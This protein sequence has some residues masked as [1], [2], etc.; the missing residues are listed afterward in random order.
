MEARIQYLFM[1]IGSN[2]CEKNTLAGTDNFI[3]SQTFICRLAP[4]VKENY[5]RNCESMKQRNREAVVI[6]ASN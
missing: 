2:R 5:S 3:R 6:D 1:P 4:G